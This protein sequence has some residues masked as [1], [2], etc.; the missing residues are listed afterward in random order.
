M[1]EISMK[2]IS[3]ILRLVFDLL[4]FEPQGLY[5]SE[6]MRYIQTSVPLS[7]F[8]SG[9]YPFAPY[10]PRYEVIIRI[11][12]IPLVRAGWLQKS[13]NGLWLI[14]D[15]GREAC[16]RHTNSEEFF[17]ESVR[18]FQEW[19]E[20][21]TNRLAQLG[22]NA[23]AF[24]EENSWEQIRQFMG[25]REIDDLR[26]IVTALLKVLGCYV[27]WSA[28]SGGNEFSELVDLICYSDPLGL[29]KQR[30]LTHITK[31]SQVSTIE[32]LTGFMSLLKPGDV[33]I[34]ISFSGITSKLR[35][36][37]LTQTQNQIRLIDLEKFVELW[38]EN[39][40]KI[41][42]EG[43]TKFPLK[44]IYFLSFPEGII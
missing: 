30:I 25:T 32:G 33:G 26:E 3:D 43:K 14:T 24:A 15:A 6:I 39:Q 29:N 13:K 16:K 31:N 27:V 12:T 4:W 22:S 9:Y 18:L 34:Y 8:E 40:D 11:G 2:R 19:N 35:E 36:Y 23:Y 10:S 17:Q 20:K 44:P 7:E 37:A 1:T 38:I 41:D 21:E 42:D 5:A 28:S